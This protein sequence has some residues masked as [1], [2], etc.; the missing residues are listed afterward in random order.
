MKLGIILVTLLLVASSLIA[1]VRSEA[2]ACKCSDLTGCFADCR[3]MFDSDAMRAGCCAGCMIG[4][5]IHG[6]S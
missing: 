4:C 5:A 3:R 2:C 1:P 6:A